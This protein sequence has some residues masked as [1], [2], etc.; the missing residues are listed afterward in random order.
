MPAAEA[1]GAWWVGREEYSKARAAFQ[2]ALAAAP[3]DYAALYGEGLAEEHLGLLPD[4]LKHLQKA[5]RIAPDSASCKRELD[6]VQKK[7]R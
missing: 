4:A 6:T 1:L 7:I 2:Q 5:C 3:G